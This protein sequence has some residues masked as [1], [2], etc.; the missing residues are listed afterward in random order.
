M[1]GLAVHFFTTAGRYVLETF[2][3]T[4]AHADTVG[5]L[6]KREGC[7]PLHENVFHV[8]N[9]TGRGAQRQHSVTSCMM[10]LFIIISEGPGEVI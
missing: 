10:C 3:D 1:R 7:F 2:S 5:G 8:P 6:R 9:S 4:W